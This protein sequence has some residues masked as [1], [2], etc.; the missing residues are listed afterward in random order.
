MAK[1]T[2]PSKVP[3]SWT[4][5][6]LGCDSRAMAC[7][8]ASSWGRAAAGLAPFPGR[9]NLIATFRSSSGSKALY[10]TPMP[11]RADRVEQ[12]VATEVRP[13]GQEP[14]RGTVLLRS[15]QGA[16]QRAHQLAA[17]VAGIDVLGHPGPLV[18]GA[19]AADVPGERVLV[20]V[21]LLDGD[22]HGP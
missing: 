2:S 6:M 4:V 1:K 7:A 21:T 20:E 14:P 16:H 9:R 8:S 17:V 13:S 11:P 18:L 19:L 12:H 5:T 22:G 3:T 15:H 10:T